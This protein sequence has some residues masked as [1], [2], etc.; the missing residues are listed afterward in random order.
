M[1]KISIKNL[2]NTEGN[3]IEQNGNKFTVKNVI[4]P[5]RMHIDF[6]EIEPK[7]TAYGFH[8]HEV[9]EEAFYI[10][11]GTGIV[12]TTEGEITVKSG[13]LINFPAGEEGAHVI[14]NPS[15]SEK[16]I[17]IDFGRNENVEIV[18]FPDNGKIMAI[19]PYS[20]GIYG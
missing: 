20:N 12:R 5:N 3:T 2:Q 10:I 11:S 14:T 17:Y 1:K 8:W 4:E 6:V 13:D 15:S 19:G 18:H 9:N 7:S 16:L